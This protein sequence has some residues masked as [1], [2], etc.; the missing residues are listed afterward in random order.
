MRAQFRPQLNIKPGIKLLEEREGTGHPAQ[1]GCH[2][3][4]NLRAYLNKGDEVPVNH[5]TPGAQW[6]VEMLSSDERGELINFVCTIGKR[7]AV[8]AVEYA[9]IGMKEGGYR[10]VKAKPHLAYRE[11][12]IE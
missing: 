5:R 1:K 6:P 2:V 10:K 4:Y 8:A 11:A 7:E 9:L 12:G 3:T